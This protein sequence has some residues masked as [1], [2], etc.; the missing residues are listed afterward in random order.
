MQ[1]TSRGASPAPQNAAVAA[2]P[3]A[4]RAERLGRPSGA[5]DA[6]VAPVISLALERPS[7]SFGQVLAGTTPS[8]LSERVTVFSTRST[9]YELTVHR[10]AF[11]PADLPLGLTTT[12]RRR[13]SIPSSPAG[14]SRDP[15][16]HEHRPVARLR[17]PRGARLRRHLAGLDRLHRPAAVVAPGHYT[18]TVTFT[19]IGK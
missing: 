8:P 4:A 15:A 1:P 3:C 9:G 11:A 13:R 17:R 14:R 5:I 2:V 16:A 12:G 6:D 10:T 19:V 18:G 7:L